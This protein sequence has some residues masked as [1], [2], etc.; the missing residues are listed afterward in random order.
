MSAD[1]E[2]PTQAPKKEACIPPQP[3]GNEA[4]CTRFC[5]HMNIRPG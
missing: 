4:S 5:E 1:E 2:Y 3:K